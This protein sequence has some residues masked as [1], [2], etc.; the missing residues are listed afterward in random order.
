ML[1]FSKWITKVPWKN[2]DIF[3]VYDMSTNSP[4]RMN[5]KIYC[6]LLGVASL[7]GSFTNV[8]KLLFKYR[9]HYNLFIAI[10]TTGTNQEC[11]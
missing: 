2:S 8:S 4:F 5:F 9:V 3:T 11:K 10:L 1:T 6:E 7:A